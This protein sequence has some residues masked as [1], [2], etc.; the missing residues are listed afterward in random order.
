ME[1]SSKQLNVSY[2]VQ[3]SSPVSYQYA[4]QHMCLLPIGESYASQG[5]SH[6]LTSQECIQGLVHP[7]L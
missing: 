5:A 6:G 3:G 2:H 1:Q 7:C 4:V